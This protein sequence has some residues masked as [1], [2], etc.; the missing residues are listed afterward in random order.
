[1]IQDW[2]EFKVGNK[3]TTMSRTLTDG[4]FAAIINATWEFGPLHTDAEHMKNTQF[5]KRMLGGPSLIGIISG[6]SGNALYSMW[7]RDGLDCVAGLGIDHVRYLAPFHP[8]DT[9]TDEIEV[10]EL[11]NTRKKPGRYVGRIKDKA[12]KQ[13]GQ[14]V[15]EME[16][17]YLLVPLG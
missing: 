6:I 8:G 12:F 14:T 13:D 1:M 4:D 7:N 16:R 3:V 17:I 15:L 11:Q 10:L 5:G 9:L 2:G